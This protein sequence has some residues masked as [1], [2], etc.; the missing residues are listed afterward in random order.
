MAGFN[1]FGNVVSLGK[2]LDEG[3]SDF[4][5]I[6]YRVAA[7]ASPPDIVSGDWVKVPLATTVYSNIDSLSISSN[8]VSLPAG[9]YLLSYWVSALA[10]NV[11]GSFMEMMCRMYDV[12]AAAAVTDSGGNVQSMG[13]ASAAT[14]VDIP[15]VTHG[16]VTISPTATTVYE[17]Q[18]RTSVTIPYGELT[19]WASQ[20]LAEL[21]IIKI[22]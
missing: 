21:S 6:Q 18:A 8:Q 20:P 10:E 13:E 9:D 14:A 11:N 1:I 3:G 16:S 19:T 15:A 7:G 5:I 4:A 12:T 17:L 22:A 2:R